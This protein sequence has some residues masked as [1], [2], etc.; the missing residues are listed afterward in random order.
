MKPVNE[1]E[2]KIGERLKDKKN[3]KIKITKQ[4]RQESRRQCTV[5]HG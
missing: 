4:S 1:K 5:K 3:T 2:A